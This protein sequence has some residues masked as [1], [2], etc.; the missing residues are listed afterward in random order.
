MLNGKPISLDPGKVTTHG[1]SS[2]PLIGGVSHSF[3]ATPPLNFPDH[4]SYAAC[5][6]DVVGRYDGNQTVTTL[7]ASVNSVR[8]TTSPTPNDGLPDVQSISFHASNFSIAAESV[9]PLTGNSTFTIMPTQA[10]MGLVVTDKATGKETNFQISLVFDQHI[11]S[12]STVKQLDDEFLSNRSFFDNFIYHFPPLE[13]LAFGTSKIPRTR[14]GVVIT[15]FVK[16]IQVGNET[17]PG[18]VLTKKGFGTI[19]F[20]MMVISPSD[21]RFTM[22]HIKMGSDPAGDV[23]LCSVGDTGEWG[24]P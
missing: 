15:S 6:T 22:A 24:D 18:N 12:L 21:R 5:K 13:R 19:K 7:S 10:D 1:E 14:Q 11:L 20:G 2:L 3:V 9:Y 4:I 16:Q 8:L 23:D 17:I